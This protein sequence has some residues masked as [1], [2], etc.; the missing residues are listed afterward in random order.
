MFLVPV[1][2]RS[3]PG[4][5]VD[6]LGGSWLVNVALSCWETLD[7]RSPTDTTSYKIEF[8]LLADLGKSAILQGSVVFE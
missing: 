7:F 4:S 5:S 1:I 3:S 2:C 6:L 8:S